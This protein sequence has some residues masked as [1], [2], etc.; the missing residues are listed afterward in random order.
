MMFG[1]VTYI[2]KVF[3]FCSG[4]FFVAYEIIWRSR[5]FCVFTFLFDDDG[6]AAVQLSV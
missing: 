1:K 3:R 5:V 4:N 6:N 2:L